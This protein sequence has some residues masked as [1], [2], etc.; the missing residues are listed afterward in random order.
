[1]IA[2]Q[3]SFVVNCIKDVD[4]A[5]VSV[6]RIHYAAG[7]VDRLLDDV[8]RVG[9]FVVSRLLSVPTVLSSVEAAVIYH[10]NTFVQYSFILS[11]LVKI[12]IKR[13][14]R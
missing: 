1:M 5:V 4:R 7:T 8:N 9:G 2:R 11:S 3:L 14:R 12:N 6:D 10:F 13:S